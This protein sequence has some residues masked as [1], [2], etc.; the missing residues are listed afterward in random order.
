MEDNKKKEPKTLKKDAVLIR[1]LRKLHNVYKVIQE[2][3]NEDVIN[4]DT[5]GGCDTYDELNDSLNDL[6]EVM[7]YLI[8][9]NT[10]ATLYYHSIQEKNFS[11]TSQN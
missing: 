1:K 11:N 7:E 10:T 4:E 5:E 8:K 6:E 3:L 9:D 2:T